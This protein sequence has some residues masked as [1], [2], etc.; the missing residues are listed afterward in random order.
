[1][2]KFSLN[3][4]LHPIVLYYPPC[5]LILGP[6][7]LTDSVWHEPLLL[8]ARVDFALTC[9][10]VSFHVF[11]FVL[12]SNLGSAPFPHRMS[13]SFSE[14]NL[15]KKL[16]QITNTQDAIQTLSLWIL[17]HKTH[18][19]QIVEKWLQCYRKGLYILMFCLPSTN[20]ACP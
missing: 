7:P 9:V 18:Y 20:Y 16:E 12:P 5:R 14:G 11:P 10:V 2:L 13:S 8:A 4:R 6:R 3:R 1:M 15:V 17:H 19:K